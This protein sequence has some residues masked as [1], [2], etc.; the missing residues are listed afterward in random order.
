MYGHTA[1]VVGP[2]VE[3]VARIGIGNADQWVVGVGLTIVSIA[4]TV[5]HATQP[6]SADLEVL[7]TPTDHSRQRGN[8]GSP[9]VLNIHVRRV[10]NVHGTVTTTLL[11]YLSRRQDHHKI[12]ERRT[13]V[14]TRGFLNVQVR[15]VKLVPQR[16]SALVVSKGVLARGARG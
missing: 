9:I 15:A 14:V 6:Y 1:M 10:I 2:T 16:R 7:P 4:R 13:T 12:A 5:R 8:Q 3:H 11:N